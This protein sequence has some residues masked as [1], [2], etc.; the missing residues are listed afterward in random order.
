MPWDATQSGGGR[1]TTVQGSNG[2]GPRLPTAVQLAN[3]C[4][5]RRFGPQPFTV[6]T[7]ARTAFVKSCS[8]VEQLWGL[9]LDAFDRRLQRGRPPACRLLA[10]A[11]AHSCSGAEQLW[12]TAVQVP[13]SCGRNL[14]SKSC[15]AS[16]QLFHNCSIPE[17]LWLNGNAKIPQNSAIDS[18]IFLV[19]ANASV[20][21]RSID[22][23]SFEVEKSCSV[24]EQLWA[25]L[26]GTRT[27][28]GRRPVQPFRHR[29]VVTQL[30]GH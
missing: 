16:E 8:R 25:K 19:A 20:C 9:S 4:G 3:G 17:Q 18:V 2:C 12:P 27:A 21:R 23:R 1:P 15:S 11:I 24:P 6:R 26:F 29:T 28:V 30:F 7:V 13:N 5:A 10:T 22:R 14:S